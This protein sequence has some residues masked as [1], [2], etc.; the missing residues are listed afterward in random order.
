MPKLKTHKGAKR[1]FDITATGNVLHRKGSI[2]Q[3]CAPPCSAPV[4]PHE[5]CVRIAVSLEL[6]GNS[7][8][9]AQEAR[10][11]GRHA[12]ARTQAFALRP[13]VIT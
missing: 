1:R 4:D 8:G 5:I 7:H 9:V 11:L 12:E 2:I 3:P 13:Q 10:R 6:K